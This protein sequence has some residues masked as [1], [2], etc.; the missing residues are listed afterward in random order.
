MVRREFGELPRHL[1]QRLEH[2]DTLETAYQWLITLHSIHKLLG[3]GVEAFIR[4][5][6]LYGKPLV[7]NDEKCMVDVANL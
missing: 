1:V 7:L 6:D 2:F 4:S 5:S 3:L